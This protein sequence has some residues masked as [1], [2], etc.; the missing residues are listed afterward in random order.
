MPR[1]FF[2]NFIFDFLTIFKLILNTNSK[3]LVL[4][5]NRTCSLKK[6]SSVTFQNLQKVIIVVKIRYIAV[7]SIQIAGYLLNIIS[8]R[9]VLLNFHYLPNR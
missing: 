9:L 6:A 5:C 4:F 1:S 8:K 2:V 7:Q 3:I